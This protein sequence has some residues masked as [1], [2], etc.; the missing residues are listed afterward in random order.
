MLGKLVQD[1]TEDPTWTE[2]CGLHS[3][4]GVFSMWPRRAHSMVAGF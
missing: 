1:R 3:S 4:H 2:G